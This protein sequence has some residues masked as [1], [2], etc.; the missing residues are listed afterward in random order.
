MNWK[1][2]PLI[3]MDVIVSLIGNTTNKAGLKV[4]AVENRNIYPT[5]RKIPDKDMETLNISQYGVL[6][7]WNYKISPRKL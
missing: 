7:K 4:Y 5:K 3:S 1:G 6:G 2:Q